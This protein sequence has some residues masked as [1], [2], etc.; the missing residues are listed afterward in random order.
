MR[1]DAATTGTAMIGLGK[2]EKN[3]PAVKE[4]APPPDTQIDRDLF[5]AEKPKPEGMLD[6]FDRFSS[7]LRNFDIQPQSPPP[8]PPAGSTAYQR[9]MSVYQDLISGV[10]NAV[11]PPG[12]ISA[13]V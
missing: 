11:A 1:I 5:G 4:Q 3:S 13:A 8:P 7:N 12:S 9:F 2:M 10:R 6:F